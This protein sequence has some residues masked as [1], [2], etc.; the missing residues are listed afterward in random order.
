MVMGRGK[1]IKVAGG[2]CLQVIVYLANLIVGGCEKIISAGS[3][4]WNDLGWQQL[5]LFII[6]KTFYVGIEI[7]QY[8]FSIYK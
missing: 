6:I 2:D 8:K 1:Q 5:L 7:T 4:W 3:W